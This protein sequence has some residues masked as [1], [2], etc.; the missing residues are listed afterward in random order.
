[1]RITILILAF[2]CTNLCVSQNVVLQTNIEIQGD[3][4]NIGYVIT[5]K[6]NDDIVFYK[7][8]ED[9]FCNGIL[10][11]SFKNKQGEEIL[12]NHCDKIENLDAI[13]LTCSNIRILGKQETIV[14]NLKVK[15]PSF[16]KDDY[17]LRC[18]I[19]YNDIYFV[20]DKIGICDSFILRQ[21]LSTEYK[22]IKN[23]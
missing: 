8:T 21:I 23:L 17:S 6:S 12:Y 2:I 18:E 9:D 22:N 16:L 3:F 13:I 4:L 14:F 19:N 5:N 15:K 20:T 10:N 7:P 11:L 1:M